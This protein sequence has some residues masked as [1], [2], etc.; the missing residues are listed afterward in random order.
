MRGGAGPLL[1]ACLARAVC[2]GAPTITT[3][4]GTVRASNACA[5]TNA[6]AYLAIPYAQPPTGPLRF[7]APQ[8]YDGHYTLT[9][10]SAAPSCPQFGGSAIA[11]G[12]QSEDWYA[13][14]FLT[15]RHLRCHG[16]MKRRH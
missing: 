4:N 13:S 14:L 10:G 16:G 9:A 15:P 1:L 2:A 12:P 7:A 8:P 11:D 3:T 6:V 5:G